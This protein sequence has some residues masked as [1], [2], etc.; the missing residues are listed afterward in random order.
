ALASLVE[1]NPALNPVGAGDWRA[2]RV[3]IRAFYADRLFAPVWVDNSQG[4]TPRGRAVLARL[5]RANEDGLD[6]TAFALP[7]PTF[8]DN[9]PERLA[10][11]ETTISA[12]L[13]AYALQASG[14]RIAPAKLSRL[15]TASPAVVDPAKALSETASA[16]EPGDVLAAYN[17]SQKGYQDLREELARLRAS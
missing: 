8:A 9:R 7:D 17:P 4:L 1:L 11:V 14:A 10:Q 6:L 15:V 12:A 13:V 2:A 16:A 5:V 3:A